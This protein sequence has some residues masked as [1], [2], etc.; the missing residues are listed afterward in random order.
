MSSMVSVRDQMSGAAR[1]SQEA[2]RVLNKAEMVTDDETF[3]EQL[4]DLARHY[5]QLARVAATSRDRLS[6]H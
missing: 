5:K 4:F 3:R 6:H 1:Y 2:V